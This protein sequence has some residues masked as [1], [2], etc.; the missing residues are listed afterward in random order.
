MDD[1]AGGPCLPN[2]SA[3][4]GDEEGARTEAIEVLMDVLEWRLAFEQWERVAER[5]GE[6]VAALRGGD[7]DALWDATERLELLGPTRVVTGRAGA[8]L[9]GHPP[10]EAVRE[11]VNTLVHALGADP[12]PTRGATPNSTDDRASA[13]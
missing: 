11:R 9:P 10:P 1:E 6:L 3:D 8:V 2:D 7:D 4:H 12:A 5:V 13:C